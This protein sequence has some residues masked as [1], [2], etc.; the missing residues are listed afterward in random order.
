M[1]GRLLAPHLK[2]VMPTW[3]LS[4]SDPYGPASATARRAADAA[5]PKE[6][7]A[8]E[9]VRFCRAEIMAMIRENILEHTPDTLSDTK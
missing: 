4:R 5:F 7:K 2:S 1:S 6:D 8:R 3:L 9:A